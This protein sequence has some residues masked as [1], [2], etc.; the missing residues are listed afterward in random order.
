MCCRWKHHKGSWIWCRCYPVQLRAGVGHFC[1]VFSYLLAEL[2]LHCCVW[3]FSSC[4]GQGY[5]LVAGQASFCGFSCCRAR[6]LEHANFSCGA[7]AWLLQ[8]MWD[9]PRPGVKPVSPILQDGFFIL[10]QS[11]KPGHFSLETLSIKKEKIIFTSLKKKKEN[12]RIF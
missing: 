6:A 9:L 3:A 1:F 11:E 4:G 5:S 12:F 7:Q 8:G 2:C 10:G